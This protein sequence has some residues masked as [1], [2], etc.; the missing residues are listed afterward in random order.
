MWFPMFSRACLITATPVGFNMFQHW[1][2]LSGSPCFWPTQD[3][4]HAALRRCAQDAEQN[5]PV[6]LTKKRVWWDEG[7]TILCNG[8][9]LR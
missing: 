1:Q 7:R 2:L 4:R 5:Q 6:R 9:V 3:A 8:C